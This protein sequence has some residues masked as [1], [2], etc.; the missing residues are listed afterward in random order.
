[1][2]F[3]ISTCAYHSLQ[4]E[5]KIGVTDVAFLLT[6]SI[7]S[8][9]L[10]AEVLG[11]ES[12]VIVASPEHPLAAKSVIHIRDLE[13][14]SILLPKHDCSY[15]MLFEQILSEEKVEVANMIE[16]NSVETIKRCVMEGIGVTMI[17]E[18][19][20]RAEIAQKKLAILPWAEDRL[21]AAI[22]MI[23][24]KDKWISPTLQAFMDTVREVIVPM[25]GQK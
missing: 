18:I 12:V 23:W 7:Q 21:E 8:S 16:L 11:F 5:L 24:H 2:G 1:V 22:L 3:D 10:T 9:H 15:K 6:D 20:V 13:N 19:A 14:Q 17:P 25:S 4:H